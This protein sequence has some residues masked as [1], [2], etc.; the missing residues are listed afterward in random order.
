[1]ELRNS[2]PK[3]GGTGA[4]REVSVEETY[5]RILP[6]TRRVGI[7]RIADITG[8]DR[9]GIPVYNAISP[10]SNDMIS[11]Y[12]GKGAT[13]LDAKT[14]AIME[15]VERFSA[16]LPVAPDA[17]GSYPELAR[18][19]QSILDPTDFNLELF[20]AYD[21]DMPISWVRGFDIMNEK[22]VLVPM[23]L[24]GYYPKFHEIPC[25][26]LG[27]TN[28][29][30]SGNSVEEAICHALCELIERDD[31]TMADLLSSRL[32]RVVG[33]EM[34]DSAGTAA[35]AS[36]LHN[37]HPNIDM[38]TLSDRAQSFAEMFRRAG[39]SVNLKNVTSET[40]IPTVLAIIAEDVAPT[41]SQSHMGLGTH[42]D[43]EVAVC[44]ALTEVAQSRVVDI[45]A[46]REDITLPGEKV[47]KWF[48]HVKRSGAMNKEAWT[49]KPSEKT[50][51]MGDLP[52]YET[53][54]VVD[55]TRLMLDGLRKRGMDQAIVVDLSPPGMPAKVVR[56]I[57]PG[58]ESWVIDRSKLGP[59]ATATWN[60]TLKTIK[61]ACT[62]SA[63]SVVR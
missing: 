25:Y 24:A 43:A 7:T 32:R 57:V 62:E 34:F 12:N 54:D 50:I 10:A 33:N 2:V 53:T 44:R 61:T 6:Y 42:P 15:A 23:Y 20:S 18:E 48:F 21:I 41:F 1:M 35:A 37:K 55:D 45:N 5:R 31:W 51:G 8:L 19:G 36:W 46:M 4:H 39:L 30:A 40:G 16:A 56:V 59:R 13:A 47:E 29:I 14:S 17:V 28:G 63:G 49:F 3:I 52:T 27:T 38:N 60:S 11:V 26:P 9:I 22:S 58:I